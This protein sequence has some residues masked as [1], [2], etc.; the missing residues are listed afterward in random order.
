MES[1]IFGT[2]RAPLTSSSILYRHYY[3]KKQETSTTAIPCFLSLYTVPA[4]R[5]SVQNRP[6]DQFIY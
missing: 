4:S 6:P 5:P 1:A 3:I 2:N